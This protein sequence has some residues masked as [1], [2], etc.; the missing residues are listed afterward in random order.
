SPAPVRASRADRSLR[1]CCEEVE[2]RTLLS[3]VTW[4]SNT[5]GN[6]STAANWSTGKVPTSTDDV[7]IPLAGITVTHDAGTDSVK[8]LVSKANLLLSG[9]SLTL[10]S[11]STA[12]G[13]LEVSGTVTLNGTLDVTGAVTVDAGATFG[14]T[15]VLSAGGLFSWHSAS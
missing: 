7:A 11:A 2:D 14:G 10:G 1:P 13:T 8:S 5:S 3:T 9:G 4:V 6:W 15:A 12:S